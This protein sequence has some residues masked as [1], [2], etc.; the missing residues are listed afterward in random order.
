MRFIALYVEVASDSGDDSNVLPSRSVV[1]LVMRHAD[2]DRH[3]A[4]SSSPLLPW[5]LPTPIPCRET[6]L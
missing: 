3:S 2:Q 1:V 6:K 4:T 5:S